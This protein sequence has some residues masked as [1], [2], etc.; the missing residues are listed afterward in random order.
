MR[1]QTEIFEN[2]GIPTIDAYA[3]LRKNAGLV[4]IFQPVAA[5]VL[6]PMFPPDYLQPEAM[7]ALTAAFA[8]LT[9]FG[10]VFDPKPYTPRATAQ[11]KYVVDGSVTQTNGTNFQPAGGSQITPLEVAVSHYN[12]PFSV[13]SQEYSGGLRLQ[14]LFLPNALKFAAKLV[15]VVAAQFTAANF[16]TDPVTAAAFTLSD[17]ATAFAKI[18]KSPVKNLILDSE[19]FARLSHSAGGKGFQ[20]GEAAHGWNG[21]FEQSDWTTAGAGVYGFAATPSAVCIVTG[22]LEAM[23]T[24]LVRQTFVAIP[25]LGVPVQFGYWFDTATRT[26][27]ASFDAVLG[28]APA[29]PAAGVLITTP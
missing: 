6:D 9:A 14:D 1:P 21:I 8:P 5:N 27:W 3:V 13:N 4:P 18:K 10:T 23:P 16:P 11:V 7:R 19:A 25:G 28:A 22:F 20:S 24:F 2:N 26:Q 15:S 29:D 17:A 12:Q